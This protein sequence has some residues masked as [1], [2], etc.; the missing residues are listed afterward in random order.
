MSSWRV[1]GL[2]YARYHVVDHKNPARFS[3]KPTSN[4]FLARRTRGF[5]PRSVKQTYF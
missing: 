5:M 4:I 3:P 2:I 1:S